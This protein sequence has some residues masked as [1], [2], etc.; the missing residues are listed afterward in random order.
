MIPTCAS[1][2]L[3]RIASA[4]CTRKSHGAWSRYTDSPTPP[5]DWAWPTMLRSFRQS[6]TLCPHLD[7]RLIGAQLAEEFDG[8]PLAFRDFHEHVPA[9]NVALHRQKTPLIEYLGSSVCLSAN[10]TLL[11]SNERRRTCS[12]LQGICSN[13]GILCRGGCRGN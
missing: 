13:R 4:K 12:L 3:H 10:C 7:R 2:S 5:S 9:K 11:E 6:I 8:V 1:I